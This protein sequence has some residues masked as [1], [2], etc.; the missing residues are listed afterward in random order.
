MSWDSAARPALRHARTWERT[1]SLDVLS[2]CSPKTVDLYRYWDSRRGPRPMPRR[3]DIDPVD[4]RAWLPRITLI[5]VGDGGERMRYRVVGTEV[6]GLRGFDPTGWSVESA[7]PREDADRVL[8]AYRDV[9]AQK[10]PVFCHPA[11]RAPVKRDPVIGVM[12]L[13]LSSDGEIVDQVLGYLGDDVGA[14]DP[15]I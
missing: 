5:E 11:E 13:P 4:M 12:L 2:W 6:V 14:F 7:F 8:G 15:V 9:I 10:K 1:S 3:A